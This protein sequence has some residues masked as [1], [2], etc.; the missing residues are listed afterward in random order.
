MLLQGLGLREWDPYYSGDVFETPADYCEAWPLLPLD[1]IT[2]NGDVTPL[3]LETLAKLTRVTSVQLTLDE[4]SSV[5][6]S[7]LGTT[8]QQLKQLQNLKIDVLGE[9]AE[10]P[11]WYGSSEE[12]LGCAW[13]LRS[14]QDLSCLRLRGMDLPFANCG[15]SE[16]SPEAHYAGAGA[17]LGY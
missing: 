9:A 1:E 4:D 16:K 14:L 13:A 11:D 15:E 7:Q 17:L 6:F 12:A 10:Q 2:V 3:V 8:L 5:T